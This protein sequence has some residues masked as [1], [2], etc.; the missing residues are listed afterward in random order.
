LGR[1]EGERD[2]LVTTGTCHFL[3]YSFDWDRDELRRDGAPIKLRPKTLSLLRTFLQRPGEVLAKNEL[4]RIVWPG[5]IVTDVVLNVCVTEL[6]RAL[7]DEAKQP[8]CLATVHRRGFRFIAPITRPGAEADL[9]ADSGK[10]DIFVG[11]RAEL[12]TL[13]QCWRRS[14]AGQFQLVIVS[15]DTGIGKTALVN[16]FF[17]ELAGESQGLIVGRG[18]CLDLHA[19]ADPFLPVI[20]A[21]QSIRIAQGGDQLTELI[22]QH[23]PSWQAHLL[24]TNNGTEAGTVARD[25]GHG[26]MVRELIALLNA[27]TEEMPV[28]LALQDLHWSDPSTIDLVVA[29]AQ[30]RRLTRLLVIVTLRPADAILQGHPRRLLRLAA[31]ANGRV[32][33]V[34][35]ELLGE[36]AVRHYLEQRLGDAEIAATLAPHLAARTDGSPLFMMALIDHLIDEEILERVGD[37]WRLT[38]PLIDIAEHIPPS[39]TRLLREQ[40]AE[41]DTRERRALE[42]ACIAGPSFTSPVLRLPPGETRDR[43]ELGLLTY[44]GPLLIAARGV[45]DGEAATLAARMRALARRTDQQWAQL[46]SYARSTVIWRTRGEIEIADAIAHEVL[47]LAQELGEETLLLSAHFLLGGNRFHCA[48]LDSARRHFE[49]TLDIAD[50][51]DEVRGSMVLEGIAA[52]ARCQLAVALL[53]RG[54]ADAGRDAL[55]AALARHAGSEFAVVKATLNVLAA[56]VC[57]L[58]RDVDRVLAL[59]DPVVDGQPPVALWTA[60]AQVMRGW[61]RVQRG[62]TEAGLADVETGFA[63]YLKSQGEAS[64]FDYQVLRAEALLMAGQRG[65]AMRVVNEGMETLARYKQMYFAPEMYRIRGELLAAEPVRAIKAADE[66]WQEGLALARSQR[67]AAFE[68]RL[69][70]LL[71]R[72]MMSA[73]WDDAAGELLQPLLA[74]VERGGETADVVEGRRLLI[75]MGR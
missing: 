52:S 48:D 40:I 56:W 11:R 29:L 15:G 61:A 20:D 65:E 71:A 51:R 21:L 63:H 70:S 13:L 74:S 67:S 7:G 55:E 62:R 54:E 39:V 16:R 72:S 17:G 8:R 36:D 45:A 32:R 9:T 2:T 73:G 6:R 5:V 43:D 19:A 59:V 22:R 27:M 49:A 53:L 38:R 37:G 25:H 50:R 28:V 10:A 34:Q 14:R 31:A 68:V 58:L 1:A 12:E 44:L 35:L 24:P 18:H 23:A 69:G 57:V 46:A 66:C 64:S 41:F 47:A 75:A 4:T 60:V 30:Q 42:A 33:E 3:S 26:P